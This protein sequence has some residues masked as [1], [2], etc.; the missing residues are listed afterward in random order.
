MNN[1]HPC[2]SFTSEH[3]SEKLVYLD[4]TL[5]KTVRGIESE[6]YH[7]D[8]DIDTIL[9]YDSCHPRHTVKGIPFNLARRVKTL[10]DDPIRA[11]RKLLS[12]RDRFLRCRYPPGVVETAIETARHLDTKE[13]R[14]VKPKINVNNI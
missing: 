5:I 7:K 1:L 8:T 9:P 14:Q 3:S 10:T 4:V 6:I 13:L 11:E 2:L 12:L